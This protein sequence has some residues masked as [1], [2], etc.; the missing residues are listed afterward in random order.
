VAFF[1]IKKRQGFFKKNKRAKGGGKPVIAPLG[2][3]NVNGFGN[4]NFKKLL[5]FLFF[6]P[7]KL[8]LNGGI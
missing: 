6:P 1:F 4:K 3:K 8:N 2:G 7:P 5:K